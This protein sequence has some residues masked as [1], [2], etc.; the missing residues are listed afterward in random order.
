[1]KKSI[2]L[3]MVFAIF[4]KMLGFSRDILLSY[5][6]GVSNISD[7]YLISIIIPTSIVALIGTGIATSYIPM[8]S[9][10]ENDNGI[11]I[12]DEFTNNVINFILIICT[13]IVILVFI[14]TEPIVRLFASGFEG[15]VLN[16]TVTFTRISIFSVY[17]AGMIYVFSGYLQMKDKFSIPA[18]MGVPLNLLIMLSI[19]LSTKFNINILSIGTAVAMGFQ[20]LFLI[21]FVYKIGLRYKLKI[22]IGNEHIRKLI[23]LSLPV[24]LGVSVTQVN[25]IV[26]KTMASH[27][28]VGGISALN[29]AERLTEFIQ[30]TFVMSIITVIYP[31]ISKLASEGNLNGL[32]KM[33]LGS[34][35]GINLLVIPVSV[36]AIILAEP[37]VRLLFG[38]GAFEEAAILMTSNALFFYSIGLMGFGLREVLS[39]AFYAL[40]DV[41]TPMINAA[42][43]LFLNIILNILLSKF[44]GIGGLALAT[45]ISATFCT[46]LLLL[47]LRE[48]IGPFGIK[49]I[50]ISFIKILCASSIMGLIL[51]ISYNY[52]FSFLSE[53]TSILISIFIAT[54]V[55]FIIIYNMKV[56]STFIIENSIKRWLDI[57]KNKGF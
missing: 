34:I 37:I 35:N 19:F 14:F 47:K 41:K 48:K 17:F 6:Y 8:Y 55:Y 30:A 56:E 43:A 9:A 23:V 26:D 51:I 25:V 49:S 13:I 3:I 20:A 27:I 29:Y 42:I 50:T 54:I 12:A 2:L 18:L 16:L 22:D 31:R 45:S 24:I 44:L 38:R 36:G 46:G 4:T 32:K 10:I 39:R 5:F 33:V 53:I 52:L 28:A 11:K 1:M 57:K 7:A 21:P 40:Q 15:E